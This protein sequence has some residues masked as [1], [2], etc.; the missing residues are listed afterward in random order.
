MSGRYGAATALLKATSLPV[1]GVHFWVKSLVGSFCGPNMGLAFSLSFC[2]SV[3]LYPCLAFT[4]IVYSRG[5]RNSHTRHQVESS[6]APLYFPVLPKEHFPL[7][8]LV[9]R[10]HSFNLWIQRQ[11]DLKV[12][13][14]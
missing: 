5:R 8:L 2:L 11:T 12:S 10:T 7:C 3:C 13:A 9:P 6:N 1:T 14:K 4:T